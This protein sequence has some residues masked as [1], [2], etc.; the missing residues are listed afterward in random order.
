MQRRDIVLVVDDVPGTLGLL[1]DTLEAAGYMVLVA[2]SA[3]A[4]LG[5]MARVTPDIILMDA[6]MPETDGFEACRR[7]KRDPALAAIPV[8][9][10]TGLT[11]T[12]DVV[13]GFAA[14]GVDYVTKPIS[15]E[16]VVARIGTHLANARR[17][18]SAQMAL[19]VAGRFFMAADRQGRVLWA[20][21]QAAALLAELLPRDA[22]ERR[23]GGNPVPGPAG[24]PPDAPAAGSEGGPDAGPRG[25]PV[26]ASAGAS[27]RDPPRS[28]IGSPIGSPTGNSPGNSP[29]NP[30]GTSSGTSPGAAT[31]GFGLGA[32]LP[33]WTALGAGSGPPPR[34]AIPVAGGR[35][36]LELHYVGQAGPDE[37]LLRVVVADPTRDAQ[38]LRERLGL[39]AREAEVLLWIGAGKSNRDIAE[40]LGLSPRTV[41]KH[42]EGIYSKIGVENRAAAAAV[43][44]RTTGVS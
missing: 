29:G 15:P 9:F 6:V 28:P 7:L 44:A 4:A 23:A 26:G 42:L 11:E 3:A 40:I 20:T 30:P 31:G 25:D 35:R 18:R 21:P 24:S 19:D 39:T 16:A 14:G 8:I 1:N 37:L 33:G 2:R 5:V 32:V 34:I 22:P 41:N 17:T 12:D 38:L 43:V 27:L 36:T 13:R 10:M